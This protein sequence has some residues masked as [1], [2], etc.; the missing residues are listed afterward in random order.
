MAFISLVFFAVFLLPFSA[1][2][3]TDDSDRIKE[4]IGDIDANI[5]K[6]EKNVLL[7][8]TLLESSNW[9]ALAKIKNDDPKTLSLI[10]NENC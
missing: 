10:I 2:A 6:G 9:N 5:K 8:N 7:F 3:S 4:M 1:L